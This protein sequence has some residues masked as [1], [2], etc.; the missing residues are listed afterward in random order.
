MKH[1]RAAAA[2]VVT[3]AALVL[4]G[5]GNGQSSSSTLTSNEAMTIP[6]PTPARQRGLMYAS[7]SLGRAVFPN[8][9]SA[10]ASVPD[11]DR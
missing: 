1:G 11:R 9:S 5:C 6:S 7:D 3:G 10:M 8:D 4:S 2:L